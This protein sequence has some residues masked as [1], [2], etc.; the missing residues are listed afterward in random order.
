MDRGCHGGKRS[1]ESASAKRKYSCG[2]GEVSQ[3]EA[4]RGEMGHRQPLKE[5]AQ[6]RHR[7][8]CYGLCKPQR[9]DNNNPNVR[10]HRDWASRTT[11][12]LVF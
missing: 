11:R 10:A 8:E 12:L 9:N 4:P 2:K 6:A 5:Q 3:E 1:R 7:E